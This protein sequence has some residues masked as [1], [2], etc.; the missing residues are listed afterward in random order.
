MVDALLVVNVHVA[1]H[2]VLNQCGSAQGCRC[3]VTGSVSI[4][5]H[6]LAIYSIKK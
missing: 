2:V 5:Q 4:V 6:A 1:I 3:V